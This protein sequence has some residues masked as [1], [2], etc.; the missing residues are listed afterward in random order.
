PGSPIPDPGTPIPD[1]R[2]RI[3]TEPL[4]LSKLEHHRIARGTGDVHRSIA[5]QIR[6]SLGTRLLEVRPLRGHEV[7]RAERSEVVDDLRGQIA[8]VE[9]PAFQVH[10]IQQDGRHYAVVVHDDRQVVVAGD[11]IDGCA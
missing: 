8:D 5:L 7:P 4:A 11:A 3:P 2:L 9:A 1:P 6:S 10:E